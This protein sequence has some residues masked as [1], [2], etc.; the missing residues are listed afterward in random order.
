MSEN[1]KLYLAN[2]LQI[3]FLGDFQDKYSIDTI[4]V[5]V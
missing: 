1:S 3:N 2:L 5:D 4:Y